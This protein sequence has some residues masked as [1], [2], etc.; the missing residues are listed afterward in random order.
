[1]EE[2]SLQAKR[3]WDFTQRRKPACR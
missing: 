1:L 2:I 3:K